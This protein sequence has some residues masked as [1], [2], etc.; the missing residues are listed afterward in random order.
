M[1]KWIVTGIAALMLAWS[2]APAGA[3][4]TTA[5]GRGG[6][7]GFFVGCCFGLR[8]VADWNEGKALHWRDWG[9]IIPYAG[10]VIALI[11]G[12]DGAQGVTNEQLVERFGAV[13]Y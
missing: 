4:T 9:P 12:V 11:N 13:Y 1:K 10:A 7:G 3:E 6:V 2:V 5:P 8:T